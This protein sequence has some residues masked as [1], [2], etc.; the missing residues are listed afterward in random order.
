MF[1]IGFEDRKYDLHR[2]NGCTVVTIQVE[3]WPGNEFGLWLPETIYQNWQIM[4]CNWV[5]DAHEDF[6]RVG[7]GLRW[8]KQLK[9]FELTSSLIPD[10]ALRCIWYENSFRNT[11]DKPLEKLSSQ[12][13]FHMVNAPEFISIKSERVWAS[14]DGQWITTDK[15]PRHKSPDPRRVSFSRQGSR[16]ERKFVPSTV[17]P[18][19]QM[20]EES[21][22]PLI[23]VEGF[24]NIGT[25]GVAARNFNHIFNNN[26]PIL[27]CLHSEG[28]P[29]PVVKPGESAKQRAVLLFSRGNHEALLDHFE[30]NV[31]K[32][33]G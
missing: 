16:P 26:D 17:F 6:E 10:P 27:R 20:E 9:D 8:T 1:K 5:G 33:L 23:M 32:K 21:T 18:S 3:D 28:E 30:K 29:I 7:D 4:W 11:S 12:N 2:P 19:A 13:C 15:T 14:I 25:V 31:K 24:R 22:H